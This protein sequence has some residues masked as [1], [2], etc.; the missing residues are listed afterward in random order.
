MLAELSLAGLALA[1]GLLFLWA[2]RSLPQE[3]WQ[4]FAAIPREKRVDGTWT[5]LN[6]TYYGAFTATGVSVAVTLFIGLAGAMRIPLS[7]IGLLAVLL[8]CLCVPAARRIAEAVEA[9]PYTFTIGGA[10]FVG[11]LVMPWLIVLMNATVGRTL[12]QELPVMGTLAA[13]SIAYAVGEGIGRLACISFGCC[14]GKPVQASP[15]WLRGLFRHRHFIFT[16]GLKKAAYEGVLESVPVIPIQ[17]VTATL[18]VAAGLVGLALFVQGRMAAAFLETAIVT[19]IWRAVSELFRADHRGQ[20]TVSAYQIMAILGAC[21]AGLVAL[22]LPAPPAVRP[23]L[24]TGLQL[25]WSPAVILGIQALWLFIFLYTG[26]SYVT[27]STI[28]LSVLRDRT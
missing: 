22:A 1:F 13:L 8:L 28:A 27:G 10:S 20:G 5:G 12:G 14:Y 19:Q 2:F 3:R 16:G 11:L 15:A 9:K 26:R 6:L 7:L 17:A 25:L 18:S 24:L 21:Y 4:I 23:S